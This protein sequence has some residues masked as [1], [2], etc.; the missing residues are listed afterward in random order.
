[1]SQNHTY[2]WEGIESARERDRERESQTPI[3]LI[4]APYDSAQPLIRVSHLLM[5]DFEVD[6]GND[7][8]SHDKDNKRRGYYPSCQC[9]VQELVNI[10]PPK[11]LAQ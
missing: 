1:M 11:K 10:R 8:E 4:T 9:L 2:T 7:D 3:I 6:D 5:I